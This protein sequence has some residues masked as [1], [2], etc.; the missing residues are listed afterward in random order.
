MVQSFIRFVDPTGLLRGVG[1]TGMP[2]T[3]RD[4]T[5]N[6]LGFFSATRTTVWNWYIYNL[7][8]TE[9]RLIFAKLGAWARAPAEKRYE[10]QRKYE[11][12][13]PQEIADCE[14]NVGVFYDDISSVRVK[15]DEVSFAF[16]R[17][18]KLG[19]E[20]ISFQLFSEADYR[21]KMNEAKENLR[22]ADEL[23]RRF[24][25]YKLDEASL[26]ALNSVANKRYSYWERR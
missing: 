8:F 13:T 1:N 23:L 16:F 5:E 11:H 2:S 20:K 12:M 14:D 9:R 10:N 22:S 7:Y 24:L 26:A 4:S 19:W 6:V 18:Q 15:G 21:R 3:E 25:P 17:K